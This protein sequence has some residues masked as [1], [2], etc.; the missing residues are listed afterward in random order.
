LGRRKR[1]WNA[2]SALTL[3]DLRRLCEEKEASLSRLSDRRAEL[4]AQLEEIDAQLSGSGVGA[5]RRRGR[6]PGRRGPGRPPKNGR[7][8]AR[9]GARRGPRGEGGLQNV[10][11]KTLGG[12]NEPMKLGDLAQA[13]LDSGYKTGSSRFAVI[14]GQRLSEMKE[15]KKAGRG[16]YSLRG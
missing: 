10:I 13:I 11:R 3:A 1:G 2:A 4:A 6:K 12:S 5:P 16:M 8:K 15:V 7:R 9:G 14:V